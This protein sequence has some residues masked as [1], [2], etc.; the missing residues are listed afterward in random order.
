MDMMKNLLIECLCRKGI[1]ICRT[2]TEEKDKEL[3]EEVAKT[4]R[5]LLKFV[6]PSDTK[7]LTSHTLYFSIWHSFTNKQYGRLLKYLLKL[8]EDKT[9]KEIEERIIEFS[10]VVEWKHVSKHLLRNLPS[11]FPNAYKP[12]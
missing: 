7:I 8:Q 10:Q 2:L 9:Q 6:D 11:K 1:A 12:F 4:W 5:N 3:Q